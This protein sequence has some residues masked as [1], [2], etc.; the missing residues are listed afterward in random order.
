MLDEVPNFGFVL[1]YTNSTWTLKADI[2]AYY[3]TQMM[4][5][6][7]D[8]NIVKMM[9][10]VDPDQEYSWE[11]LS[12][13]L[14]AGYL[15]RAAKWM[16]KIGNRQPWSGGNY[17]KDFITLTL[18]GFNTDSLNIQYRNSEENKCL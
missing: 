9:P 12:G 4:N 8:N 2:A 6:M 17:L 16:P 13:G 5:Y 10:V 1:G 11:P 7:R 15:Q 3:F 18:Q 14:T